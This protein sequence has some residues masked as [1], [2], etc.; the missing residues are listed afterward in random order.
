MPDYVLK[1]FIAGNTP[2]SRSAIAN[3]HAICEQ[4]LKDRYQ[5]EVIDVVEDPSR[6]EE[7]R[8]I[9]TPTLLCVEPHPGRRIV[10]DLSV[11]DRVL[12]ALGIKP[13]LWTWRKGTS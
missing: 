10:G 11:T 1:L 2:R 13:H 4:H 8:I 9:A 5:L 7:E 12:V 6:A 3:L